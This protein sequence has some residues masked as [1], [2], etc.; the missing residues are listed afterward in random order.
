MNV[1]ELIELLGKFDGECPVVISKGELEIET[2]RF[3]F[4]AIVTSICVNQ[5]CEQCGCSIEDSP[6]YHQ[7]DLEQSIPF[8]CGDCCDEYCE[9]DSHVC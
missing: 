5:R 6:Y 2:K 8:C 3:E 4:G 9:D 1:K 7:N